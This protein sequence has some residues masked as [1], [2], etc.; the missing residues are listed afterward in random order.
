V[1]VGVNDMDQD[2]ADRRDALKLLRSGT[3]GIAEWNRLHLLGMKARED[4]S[5]A[6]LTG[7]VLDEVILSG[8]NLSGA[9]L[10]GADL[11]AANLSGA[12]LSGANLHRT[13]LFRADL[14]AANL[15]G[16]NLSGANLSGVTGSGAI[17]TEADL[18]EASLFGA[19]FAGSY[20]FGANLTGAHC[21]QTTF[22][23][24]D[25]SMVIGLKEVN[26]MGPSTIGINTLLISK[27]QIPEG[28]L[29]DCG[30]PE[31]WITYLPSMLGALAPI[32]F[33]SCFI[34]YSSKDG[35]F[36]ERLHADLQA[37]GVRCWFA[38]EDLKIGA[39]LRVTL[40]ESI[41]V[42]EKLLLI[43]SKHSV[44]SLWVEKEVETAMERER[45]ENR[46]ILFPIRLDDAV[47]KVESGWPA[48]IRR[49]RHIGDFRR[50]KDHDAYT[51]S[52]D[53][54]LRDLNQ[55]EPAN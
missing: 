10:S 35:A 44:A 21:G 25:L 22:G 1:P 49:S 3:E 37:K 28:F 40:D 4:L 13:D 5:G 46:I 43:L 23:N 7:L 38:P 51:K 15:H 36:A 2:Q 34:S 53:R 41:R 9:N 39:K 32:Q 26:H 24:I 14:T 52:L 47:M 33:Y 12:N 18:S 19:I 48:D 16:A 27:G 50:W 42:H 54:L 45:R 29:R 30:V 6:N 31:Q 17:F 8:T 11:T 20:L 55:T